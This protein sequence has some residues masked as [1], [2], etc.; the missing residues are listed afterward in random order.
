MDGN[1]IEKLKILK[2]EASKYMKFEKLVLYGS[3]SD[4]SNNQNSEN[5]VAFQTN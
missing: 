4:G 2:F 1:I 3:Y 5:D